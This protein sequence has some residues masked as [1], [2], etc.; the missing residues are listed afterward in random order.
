MAKPEKVDPA[1]AGP[2]K[3]S[4]KTASPGTDRIA[5][6]ATKTARKGEGKGEHRRW[7]ERH[8]GEG[9]ERP[10]I[11]GPHRPMHPPAGAAKP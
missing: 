10:A 8:Q 4:P 6:G 3:V 2:G 1:K 9:G 7:R 11:A 5:I